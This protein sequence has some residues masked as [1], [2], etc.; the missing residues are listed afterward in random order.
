MNTKEILKDIAKRTN[1]EIYLGVVGPVRSGNSSFV[2]LISYS[3]F[4]LG[5]TANS[6]NLLINVDLPLLT[7][8]TT[9]K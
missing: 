5:R 6:I 7:G 2:L 4:I 9:P 1:G 8:P 3:S